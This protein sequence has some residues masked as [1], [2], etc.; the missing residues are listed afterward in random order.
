[1]LDHLLFW[2]CRGLGF[3]KTRLRD[4]LKVLKS[5]ILIIAE[6]F[7]Q[8]CKLARWQG[9]LNFD[10]SY[11][12]GDS[13]G[14]L[15]IFWKDE[16]QVN[17]LQESNQHVTFIINS[18]LLISAVYAKCN[19]MEERQLWDSLLSF[20]VL[21]MPWMIIGD[22]NTICHD[23]ER[24]GGCPRLPRA[25]EDFSSFIQ[26]GGLIE[27]PFSGNKLSWCNGRGGLTRSWARL[28]RALCNTRLLDRWST[29][30]LKYLPRKSSDHAPMSLR[31]ESSDKRY[32][33][34]I[35][36]FQQMWTLHEGFGEFVH[37][38]WNEEVDGVG[39]WKLA[40]KLKKVKNALRRWNR[41]VFGWT[42]MHL[43]RLE[44]KVEQKETQLQESYSQEVEADMLEAQ[45]ELNSWMKREETRIAQKIKN[46]WIGHGEV[47]AS[48][49]AALRR[50]RG[51][52]LIR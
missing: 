10:V 25:M 13:G 17:I 43:K 20:G 36:R 31:L 14:K 9:M 52:L 29:V 11:S 38:L 51:I 49:F 24:R 5:K 22:F 33:P 32:G 19:Y 42:T 41:E 45:A 1:M 44:E 30:S 37:N 4:M 3:S 7:R 39:L 48:F 40:Y 15:W 46:T 6:P 28:D 34:S 47:N 35:F 23:G 50:G 2:N 12:N 27:V 16:V 21:H 18:S 8:D 26:N